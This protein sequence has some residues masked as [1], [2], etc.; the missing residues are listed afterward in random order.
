MKLVRE[1]KLFE[2]LIL[3][4]CFCLV[5]GT[6][7]YTITTTTGDFKLGYFSPTNST[8]RY[9]G[10]WYAKPLKS[11]SGTLTISEDGNLVVLDEQKKI[12]WS[13]NI[14][15]YGNLVLQENKTGTSIWESFQHPA[16]TNVPKM[17]LSTNVRTSK[18]VQLT[19]WTNESDPF[20]GTFSAA[21]DVFNLPEISI[22]NGSS[23]Y[24][25]SGPW[26]SRVF[27]GISSMDS[28]FLDGFRLT[29]DQEGTFYLTFAFSNESILYNF[30][31]NAQG[32]MIQKNSYNGH[33]WEAR[34]LTLETKCDVY[35]KCGAYGICNSKNSPICNCLVGF[36]PKNIEEWNRG[37]W[38]SGCVRRTPLQCDRVTNDG[39]EGKKDGFL[40][41]KMMKVP[42]F[43]DR[44]S[45]TFKDECRD[46]C[47]KNFSNFD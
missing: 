39:E 8:N 34:G 33:N 1:T 21:I 20:I 7:T 37:N 47:L 10:I 38:S 2:L 3:L 32:N 42:Y 9:V 40:K 41:L 30:V 11:L 44:S 28:V 5:F 46:Q 15:D 24:W 12:I 27:I 22:W 31:L 18:K 25:C 35:G 43:V 19:S 14:S 26:N 29:G 6:A 45:S 17:K 16:D 13:S 23:R 4:A 36:E